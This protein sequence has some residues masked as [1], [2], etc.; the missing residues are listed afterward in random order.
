MKDK[1]SK[2]TRTASAQISEWTPEDFRY[3]GYLALYRVVTTPWLFKVV[4]ATKYPAKGH[5]NTKGKQHERK[6]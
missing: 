2:K 3:F 4:T 1:Y 6:E 5:D